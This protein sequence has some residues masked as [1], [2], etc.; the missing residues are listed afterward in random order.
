M[1]QDLGRLAEFCALPFLHGSRSIA[2]CAALPTSVI[3]AML[4]RV[5]NVIGSDKPGF[6]DGVSESQIQALCNAVGGS[7]HASDPWV[8]NS[9][10]FMESVIQR[11]TESL[12]KRGP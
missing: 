12:S 3:R 1:D 7:V 5:M 2:M 8:S 9:L 6:S 11:S 10:A 4:G